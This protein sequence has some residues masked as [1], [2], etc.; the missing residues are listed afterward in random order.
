[1]S[2]F[3]VF[4]STMLFA[5]TR[6][7]ASHILQ[8]QSH[9]AH[10][11]QSKSTTDSIKF[12]NAVDDD[13]DSSGLD[14]LEKIKD[15]FGLFVENWQYCFYQLFQENTNTFPVNHKVYVGVPKYI[16]YHSLLIAIC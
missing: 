2:F 9:Q 13:Q 7:N 1:M 3:I 8:K 10:K 5:N 11:K 12:F 15:T 6:K 16:L 4:F 14:D